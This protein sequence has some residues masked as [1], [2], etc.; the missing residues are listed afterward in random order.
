MAANRMPPF[1]LLIKPAGADCNLR[2]AYCFYLEKAA[3]YPETV[4][5]RMSDAVLARL[6]SSYLATDQPQ[7]AFG[8]QGGEPTLMGLDFYQRVVALQ[9]QFGR[10]GSQVSNGLQTNGTLLN[11]AWAEHLARYHFLVGVSLDG[12]PDLHD[13]HRVTVTGQPTYPRVM[14]GIGALRRRRV[15]FNILTLV[16]RV[17][18]SH[19]QA[20]Y[21]H[22]VDA[23]FHYQQ[24]IP[25]V[26]FDG[27][28][29]TLPFSVEPEQWGDFLCGLFDGWYPAD[30]RTVSIRL[31]DSILVRLV[32][33][34]AN[35]CTMGRDC[36]QY[37]LVEH[38]GDV[39]PCDFFAEP[40]WKLGNIMETDWP[41]LMASP[42][43]RD[44][45]AR[46]SQWHA[47]CETCPWLDWCAG[48]CPKHRYLHGRDPR[49][50]SFLCA[51]WQRFYAH[52]ADRFKRLAETIR[53]DRRRDAA[54]PRPAPEPP[55]A[56]R[57]SPCPCGS[58]RKYKN[59]CGR[60]RSGAAR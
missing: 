2:C 34:L 42:R 30:T 21:R 33:G 9:Q 35:V 20:V 19:P 7:Y 29:G 4:H 13:V 54:V 11:D 5:H 44:F 3:L 37:F 14:A 46:K 49:Q 47:A 51:G 32:D 15:D 26:A 12:P 56:G 45:G 27:R 24:Y 8:W 40:E 41:E 6:V 50:L 22:L 53:Q 28:G 58:G 17:N 36:R 38:T 60:P 1:S 59:C 31:F 43:Y 57:N 55:E 48:D 18:G 25:G 52:T 16:N 23:G 39:Y 10:P